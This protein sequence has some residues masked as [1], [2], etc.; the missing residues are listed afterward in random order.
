MANRE[1]YRQKW[2]K[3]HS[4]YEKRA[5]KELWKVFKKWNKQLTEID[6]ISGLVETQ[7]K[8]SINEEDLNQAYYNIYYNI[9][10]IHGARIGKFINQGLKF[11]TLDDFLQFFESELL[12]YLRE[13]GIMRVQQIHQTYLDEVFK[14]FNDRLL[15]GK[16]L[17]ETTDEI[18][19]I[20]KKRDYYRWQANRIARTETTGA[21]NYSATLAGQ[22]SGFVM[23]KEW[24]SASDSRVR[25]KPKADYDHLEMNGKKV[26][27][28]ENFIFNPNTLN[29][30]FL[31]YPADPKGRAGNVINCRCTIAVLPKKDKNG[32][33]IRTA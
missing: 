19:K 15:E 23:E 1:K 32:N 18:F 17:S 5:F 9:G 27:L 31:L 3:Y 10:R 30:D 21:A 2:L 26:G 13:F 14:L 33:L 7:I 25:R 20:L 28:N 16:T 29:T 12:E 4:S 22:R 6:Y 24:I 8:L 11:F